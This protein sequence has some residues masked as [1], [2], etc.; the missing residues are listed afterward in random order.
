MSPVFIANVCLGAVLEEEKSMSPGHSRDAIHAHPA[1]KQMCDECG[2]GLLIHL[3]LHL[4]LIH[5]EGSWRQRQRHR[6]KIMVIQDA[7]HVRDRDIRNK[8]L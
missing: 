4:V 2:S 8:H 1:A 3:C 7:N 5:R 6:D